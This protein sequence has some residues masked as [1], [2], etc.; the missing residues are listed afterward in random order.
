[1][2]QIDESD[3]VPHLLGTHKQWRRPKILQDLLTHREQQPP[4]CR[5]QHTAV[6]D[7]LA[8]AKYTSTTA[9]IVRDKLAR[10][11]KLD[12]PVNDTGQR[13]TIVEGPAPIKRILREGRLSDAGG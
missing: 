12:E 7:A 2:E 8:A 1:M 6:L 11:A 13:F 5:Q 3:G 10:K 9:A 4:D